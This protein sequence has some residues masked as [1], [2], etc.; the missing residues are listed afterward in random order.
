M[1]TFQNVHLYT[2]SKMCA[3]SYKIFCTFYEKYRCTFYENVHIFIKC[4]ENLIYIYIYLHIF[5]TF[6]EKYRCTF[7]ENV[8]IFIKCASVLICSE[9]VHLLLGF[10]VPFAIQNL[11]YMDLWSCSEI[12]PSSAQYLGYFSTQY[13]SAQYLT[14]QKY[15]LYLIL[16]IY[17][18]SSP[19]PL[20]PKLGLQIGG[21]L[22]VVTLVDHPIYVVN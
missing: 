22:I 8:H 3:F 9:N 13:I 6:Y 20:K 2:F 11:L 12:I 1:C 17:F 16:V 5:C 21:I 19:T 4:A 10:V 7:Y 15:F 18:F 14:M